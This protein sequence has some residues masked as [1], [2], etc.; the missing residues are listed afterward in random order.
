MI[1]LLASPCHTRAARLRIP[2]ESYM[3][4]RRPKIRRGLPQPYNLEHAAW[5]VF[6]HS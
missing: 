2:C 6:R 5:C 3:Q 4:R 1:T